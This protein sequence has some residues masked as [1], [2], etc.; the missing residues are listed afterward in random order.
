MGMSVVREGEGACSIVGAYSAEPAT[1]APGLA[2][3]GGEGGT[4]ESDRKGPHCMLQRGQ[5]AA[6]DQ[7][8][9]RTLPNNC[10]TNPSIITKM[11]GAEPSRLPKDQTKSEEP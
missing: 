2:N 1:H 7:M 8:D 9:A 5:P 4:A 6:G 11:P 3:I 10:P